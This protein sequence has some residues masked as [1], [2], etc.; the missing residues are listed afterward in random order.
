MLV[1]ALAGTV[2]ALFGW[3][4]L[5]VGGVLYLTFGANDFPRLFFWIVVAISAPIF[6]AILYRY[7]DRAER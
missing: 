4:V 3:V 5:L 1:Y 6:F 7:F 2:V